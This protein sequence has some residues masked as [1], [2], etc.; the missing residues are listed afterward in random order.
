MRG[1]GLWVGLIAGI[2]TLSSPAGAQDA[3]AEEEP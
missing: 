1:I 2:L 3:K